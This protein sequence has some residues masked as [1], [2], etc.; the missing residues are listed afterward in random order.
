MKIVFFADLH[1]EAGFVWA[2]PEVGRKWRSSVREALSSIVHLAQEVGADA[3]LVGG[4]L[5]EHDRVTPDTAEFLRASFAELEPM[6][7][8]VAPGNHDWFGPESV[9]RRVDWSQNVHVFTEARLEPVELEDGLYLWGAAHRAPANTP[10]FLDRFRVDR[11][12]VN[13]ALFHGS[14]QAAFRYEAEGKK[15]HAPFEESQI[16]EAGL[17]HAFVGHYHT[18]RDTEYLTYPGNPEPLGFGETGERGAVVA[19]ITEDGK[20]RRERVRV[21][22][23]PLW[24]LTVD[25]TGCSNR[26]EVRRRVRDALGGKDGVARVTLEGEL[27]P[28]VDLRL[29]QDLIDVAPQTMAVVPRWGRVHVAYDLEVLREEAGI[30]GEFVRAV[31]ADESLPDDVRQ[32]VLI[33]GLRALDGREDLEVG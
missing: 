4:D 7:V 18:P 26:E 24:D 16:A 32:K 1:L 25:V 20:V 2:G 22:G 11:D 30:R 14:E 23:F 29:P 21:A 3:L 28:E 31:L 6:R 8:F 27:A 10:G 9:Y 13:I 12:G 19:E 5:Y 33:T 15:P 17:V